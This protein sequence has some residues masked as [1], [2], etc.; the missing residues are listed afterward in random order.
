MHRATTIL[1]SLALLLASIQG[2]YS[3]AF[4]V[5]NANSPSFCVFGNDD[6]ANIKIRMEAYR[7]MGYLAIGFGSGMRRA[8][9]YA[10]SWAADGAV[11]VT[12]R[13]STSASEPQIDA[14]QALTVVPGESGLNGST[15][16]ATFTRPKAAEPLTGDAQVSIAAGT[17]QSLIWA[18]STSPVVG[19]SIEYHGQNRGVVR[20][21]DM[22]ATT[23]AFTGTT[24]RPGTG[25][26]NG[27]QAPPATDAGEDNKKKL[28]EAHGALMF[29]AWS[30]IAPFGI[31]VARF[32]K[33]IGE[34]WFRLHVGA[35]LV[36]VGGLNLAG[37][38][39]VYLTIDTDHFNPNKYTSL[40][41]HVVIG[42]IVFILTY[43]Q[44]INGLIIDRLFDPNR[45]PVVP[46]WDRLHWYL[47]RVTTLLAWINV[48]LGLA[49]WDVALFQDVATWL[50]AAYGVWMVG[51]VGVFVWLQ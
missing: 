44:I 8:E 3:Q 10:A 47:G 39:T 23:S 43:I 17:P 12:R 48:P 9:V 26:G 30:V 35:L 32:F 25:S 18:W 50:Y 20:N 14:N 11:T 22:L 37:F 46:W 33:G 15:Y 6:G 24:P 28:V 42:L 19:N 40:G 21:I 45:G 51:V 27:T 5:P 41:A 16:V 7:E 4:C 34:W 1:A 13:S 36:G 38:I 31:I 49:L 2:A 29:V